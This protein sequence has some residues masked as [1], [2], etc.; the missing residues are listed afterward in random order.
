L[1]KIEEVDLYRKKN[2]KGKG[3]KNEEES[4]ENLTGDEAIENDDS[5]GFHQ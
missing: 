5:H 4:D 2:K 1:K 3:K